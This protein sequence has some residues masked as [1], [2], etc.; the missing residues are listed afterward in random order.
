[1][2]PKPRN[3]TCPTCPEPSE[4]SECINNSQS[5]IVWY[6]NRTTYYR[7]KNKTETQYCEIETVN[8]SEI[9]EI[10]RDANN[11]INQARDENKN[12]SEAEILF[13]QALN[14]FNVGNYSLAK[15]L[16]EQAKQ[17]ALEAEV[18]EVPTRAAYDYTN[19]WILVVILIIVIIARLI[20]YRRKHEKQYRM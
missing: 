20:L 11:T 1:M 14:E 10:I 9:E 7:C 15:Q 2:P 18:I 4:W 16:A 17:A 19:L 3:L 13:D 12:V 5:R 8:I 6:C